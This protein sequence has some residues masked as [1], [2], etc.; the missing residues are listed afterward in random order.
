MADAH[1]AGQGTTQ[2]PEAL[3]TAVEW[4]VHVPE[5]LRVSATTEQGLDGLKVSLSDTVRAALESLDAWVD[6]EEA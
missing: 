1:R 3:T 5:A 2:P 6:A 4:A